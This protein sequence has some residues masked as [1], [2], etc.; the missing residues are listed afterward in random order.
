[1]FRFIAIRL[2]QAILALFVLSLIVFAVG[3]LSGSPLALLLS[4]QATVEDYT[5]LNEALGLDKPPIE[6]YARFIIALSHGDLGTSYRTGVPVSDLIAERFPASLVLALSA[7]ILSWLV[8]VPLGVIAAQLRS[9]RF[10]G[11]VQGI[12]VL[13]QSAPAF[14]VG[15][16]LIQI[17]AV[18]LHWLPSGTNVTPAGIVLPSVTLALSGVAGIARLLRSSMLNVLDSDMIT[19]A[20]AKGVAENDVIWKHALRNAL[21]PAVGYGG[22]FF[23]NLLT[24]V[25]VTEAVFAWP[26]LGLLTYEA[27]VNRDFP[28]MQGVVLFSGAVTI[29]ANMFVDVLYVYIDPR[30]R[31]RDR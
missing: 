16:V 22:L 29:A 14:W 1:M 10:S 7:T 2:V 19:F 8:G 18:W 15:I 4:P 25:V 31:Y 24:A 3:R 27:I 26:G 23:V 28:V 17:F 9:T 11:L 21:L 12:S 5:R 30:V 20:R 6:Q 13:G